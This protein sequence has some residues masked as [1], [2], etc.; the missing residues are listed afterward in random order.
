VLQPV[1]WDVFVMPVENAAIA[2]N[3]HPDVWTYDNIAAMRDQLK[4]PIKIIPPNNARI[5]LNQL[6]Q[7]VVSINIRYFSI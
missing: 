6:K 4:Y 2:D 3:S 1:D 5:A 7:S